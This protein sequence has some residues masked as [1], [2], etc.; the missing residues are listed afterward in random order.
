[1]KPAG[2]KNTGA[3]FRANKAIHAMS[4]GDRTNLGTI[5]AATDHASDAFN[6]LQSFAAEVGYT[7]GSDFPT[8]E[9]AW[10]AA[11][12]GKGIPWQIWNGHLTFTTYS[13]V[14]EKLYANYQDPIRRFAHDLRRLVRR[15]IFAGRQ[16]K[17]VFDVGNIHTGNPGGL[18]DTDP[19]V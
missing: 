15:F 17:D 7:L 10:I 2:A 4:G 13:V 5:L 11:M 6:A 14:D 9:N 12:L 8:S 19:D 16:L 1:M 3:W 18:P